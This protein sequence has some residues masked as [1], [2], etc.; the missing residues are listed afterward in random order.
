[1]IYDPGSRIPD[2]GSRILD[3][4]WT[5]D[6]GCRVLDTGLLGFLSMRLK[7]TSS[8]SLERGATKQNAHEEGDTEK[9]LYSKFKCYCDTNDA[10]KTEQIDTLSKSAGLLESAIDNVQATNGEL[11]AQTAQFKA[12]M[13]DNKQARKDASVF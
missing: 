6:P 4:D 10:E 5:L 2:P 8:P 12:D 3:P 1:M 9:S 13:A 7:T 11:S